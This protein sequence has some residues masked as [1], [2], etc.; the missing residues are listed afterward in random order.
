MRETVAIETPAAAA[1]VASE[2][3]AGRG[4]F[5]MVRLGWDPLSRENIAID[6]QTF[7]KL[8]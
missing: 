8:L 5:V 4:L 6:R 7:A 1:T 3:G 2:A